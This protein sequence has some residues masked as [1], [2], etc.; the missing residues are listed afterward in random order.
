M[1]KKLTL[2]ISVLVIGALLFAG[3]KAFLSPKAVKGAKNITIE[4][5]NKEQN[6]DKSFS[7]NTDY[8]FLIDLLKEN[9]KE[10]G[11]TFKEFDFGTM[12]TGM[13]NY[14]AQDSK[15][16]FFCISVNGTDA[17]AGPNEIPLNDGDVIRFE[18]RNY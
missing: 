12:V 5:V 14:E 15:K 1:K 13:M 18:L 9:Q 10:L 17:T 11:V 7:Y 4:V 8:E 2:I 16:E 3:Y 6:V